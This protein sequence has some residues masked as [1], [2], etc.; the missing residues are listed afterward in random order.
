[1]IRNRPTWIR[2]LRLFEGSLEAV[3]PLTLTA[4][5]DGLGDERVH[6]RSRFRSLDSPDRYALYSMHD[7]ESRLPGQRRGPLAGIAPGDHTLTVVR[8][9]R[10]VPLRASALALTIFTAR[11][12]AEAAVVAALAHFVERAVST[13]QPTYLLL[14]RSVE[15]PRITTLL[16]GILESLALEDANSAAFSLDA[17]LPELRPL[18]SIDPEVFSYCRDGELDALAPEIAPY[19]V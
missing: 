1:V 4:E 3:A 7:T 15:Q 12:G 18:L 14:A 9:F 10:R 19:A 8:E 11:S 17:L 2:G 5:L 6:A 13:Y 16:T